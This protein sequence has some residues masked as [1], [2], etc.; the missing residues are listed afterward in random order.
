MMKTHNIEVTIIIQQR[1]DGQVFEK[2]SMY[3]GKLKE[4]V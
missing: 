3:Q 1:K 2:M 4:S